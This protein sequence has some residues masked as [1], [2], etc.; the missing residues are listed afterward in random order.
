MAFLLLERQQNQNS[1]VNTIPKGHLKNKDP[2]SVTIKD[3]EYSDFTNFHGTHSLGFGIIFVK[4][5]VN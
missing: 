5:E 3:S 2:L 1:A 4:T